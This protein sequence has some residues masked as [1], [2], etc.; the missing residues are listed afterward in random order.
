MTRRYEKTSPQLTLEGVTETTNEG[1]GD[2]H[3]FFPTPPWPTQAIVP[4]LRTFHS[5]LDPC[6]G[7]GGILGALPPRVLRMGLEI[8]PVRGARCFERIG[9]QPTICDALADDPLDDAVD[10]GTWSEV[11]LVIMNPPFALAL[12]FVLRALA[13]LRARRCFEIA[14]LLRLAFLETAERAPFHRQNPSDVYPLANRPSFID[15]K[16]WRTCTT[17][18]GSGKLVAVDVGLFKCKGCNG[19]GE[20]KGGTDST[21]Y[22]WFVWPPRE[23]RERE[24]RDTRGTVYVLDAVDPAR[25]TR[26]PRSAT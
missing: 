20:V 26:K 15:P 12:E 6:C 17:C 10:D 14:V 24:P 11:D 18:R 8:E 9:V 7:D 3:D 2:G 4:H 22:A 23:P 13:H 19:R 16:A 21:A 5:A 25:K 1:I